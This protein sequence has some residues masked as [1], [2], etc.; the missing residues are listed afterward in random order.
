MPED[1]AVQRGKAQEGPPWDTG[2]APGDTGPAHGSIL[3]V[4]PSSV[5]VERL[6]LLKVYRAL[7]L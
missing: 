4:S 6:L 2:A 3:E 7:V 1:V 5:Q